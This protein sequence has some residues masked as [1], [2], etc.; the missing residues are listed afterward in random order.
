MPP[1]MASPF[2]YFPPRLT[3]IGIKSFSNS[4][5]ANCTG[6]NIPLGD[7]TSNGAPIAICSDLAPIIRAF[8]YRVYFKV[9]P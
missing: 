2:I 3:V 6:S 8:S 9:S 4:I 5:N 1:Y 7:S